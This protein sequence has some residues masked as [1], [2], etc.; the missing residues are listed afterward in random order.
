MTLADRRGRGRPV[1]PELVERRRADIIEAALEVFAEIGYTKAGVADIMAR[2]G[3]GKGTFYQYFDSKKDV[4]DGA[5]D[6]VVD[7]VTTLI[8]TEADGLAVHT[9]GNLEHGLRNVAARLFALCDER[10]QA[11]QVLLEGVQEE[12]I[13]QRLLGLSANLEATLA[14]VLR[15]NADAGLISAT[16][17]FDF[18]AHVM[19][20]MNLGALL[21]LLRGELDDEAGRA[22]YVESCVVTARVLGG[23]GG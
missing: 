17:D 1:D 13:R 8:T 3:L 20:S 14:T 12:D 7:E 10:P 21:K 5:I 6:Q 4:F 15:H 18:I 19:M 9:V 23:T 11:F 16:L 22:A 2:A